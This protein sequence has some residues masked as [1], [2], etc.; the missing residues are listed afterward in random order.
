MEPE[1]KEISAT[2]GKAQQACCGCCCCGGA[3]CCWRLPSLFLAAASG[4][5]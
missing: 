1:P 5:L 4:N 3:S 2:T